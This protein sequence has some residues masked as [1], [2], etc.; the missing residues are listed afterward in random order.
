MDILNPE[1][2]EAEWL[3]AAQFLSAEQ[4]WGVIGYAKAKSSPES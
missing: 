2:D 1:I 3:S 4:D